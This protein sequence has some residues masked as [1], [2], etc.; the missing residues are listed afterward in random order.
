MKLLLAGPGTGKTTKVKSIID[1]GFSS[2]QNILV[3]S[4]TNATVTDLRSS[5]RDYSNVSC[6]T[7]HSYALKINHLRN[8][9]VLS[10]RDEEKIIRSHSKKMAITFDEF[11]SLIHCITFKN[12]V[13][14]CS[15]F[16]RDNSEYAKENIGQIDLLIVD[17]FQDFNQGERNLVYSISEYADETILL[18]DD[19][20]SIYGFKDA[21]PEGIISAYNDSSI[22][23]L[24]HENICYRCPDDI[25][26]YSTQLIIRNKNRIR[27]PWMK[28]GNSGDIIF[29]QEMSREKTNDYIINILKKIPENE[30]R[31]ILS[32]VSFYLPQL[33]EKLENNEIK[34]ENF[35]TSPI[36]PET[37]EKLWWLKAIYTKNKLIHILFLAKNYKLLNRK[38]YISILRDAFQKGLTEENIF[39]QFK[40]EKILI[41]PF[42]DYLLEQPKISDFLQNHMEYQNLLDQETEEEMISA[43]PKLATILFPNP[44]FSN[45]AVNLMS[46][47]KS[48]GL[49]AQHVIIT[50]INEG[51]LPND[52]SGIDTIES[53]RRLLF[54]GMT[55]TQKTLY[56]ISTVKWEGKYV[57]KVDKSKFEYKFWEKSYYSKTSRFIDEMRK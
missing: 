28:S 45:D 44:E 19:D 47:Y 3:L 32:P 54:V 38:K 8:F 7:L 20:Q 56:L 48:K 31:L 55:R 43:I 35:W 9:Y 50:D 41:S 37:Q 17:E 46:I 23:R 25:V 33:L 51:V 16:I 10:S 13:A 57:H 5:F 2:S 1:V 4:F 52:T 11:C 40:D 18:G 42:V 14:E 29:H 24:S 27:K 34:Y 49:Q 21:D 12:M 30:T 26:F 53:Q 36:D 22:E 6:Y 39:Q 15:S